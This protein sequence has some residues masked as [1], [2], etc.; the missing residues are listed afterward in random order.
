L[1]HIKVTVSVAKE[2]DKKCDIL[3]HA[4]EVFHKNALWH[5][6][7]PFQKITRFANYAMVRGTCQ[8][9][10]HEAN[11]LSRMRTCVILM[12]VLVKGNGN[13]FTFHHCL[14]L[15]SASAFPG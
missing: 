9:N 12:M 2:A 15:S 4:F 8:M 11:A 6:S 3:R 14:M 13:D 1:R 7:N 5:W 10:L